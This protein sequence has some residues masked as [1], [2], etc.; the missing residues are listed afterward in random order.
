MTLL[1]RRFIE[2]MTLGLT[3]ILHVWDQRNNTHFNAHCLPEC[4][5]ILPRRG[6]PA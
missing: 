5:S 2:D 1:R 6:I 3:A 4:H